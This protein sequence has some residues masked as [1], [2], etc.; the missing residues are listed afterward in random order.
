MTYERAR[1]N[2]LLLWTLAFVSAA[3]L[4]WQ[5][6]WPAYTGG[7][8]LDGIVGIVL[9]LYICSRPAANGID[10]LFTERGAFGQLVSSVGGLAWF[11]LNSIV[12]LMGWFVISVGAS[13]LNHG[14]W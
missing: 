2:S 13:R 14:I 10:L 8:T 12:M 11:L 1:R 6:T 3:Y 7:D 5:Y 9:G 4:A